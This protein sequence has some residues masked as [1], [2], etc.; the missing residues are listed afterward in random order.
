MT[1]FPKKL[2]FCPVTLSSYHLCYIT[3]YSPICFLRI[4][5]FF[6]K[7]WFTIF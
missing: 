6:R 3:H 1:V 5:S 4:S 7:L 2:N